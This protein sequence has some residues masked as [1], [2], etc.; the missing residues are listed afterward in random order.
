MTTMWNGSRLKPLEKS[1][2]YPGGASVFADQT[3]SRPQ[4]ADTVARGQARTDLP[5]YE[6]RE[7]APGR[8]LV[9]T[10]PFP[11]TRQILDRGEERFNIYCSPCH[12]LTGAGNGMIV[13]RGFPPPPSYYIPRLRQA[14]V[15]HLYDVITNGYGV[16]YSYND[17]VQPED[18]W[19]IVAYIRALPGHAAHRLDRRVGGKALWRGAAASVS[20]S[21]DTFAANTTFGSRA[22][23]PSENT[24]KLLTAWR[25]RGLLLG[26]GL[27]V[28]ALLGGIFAPALFFPAYLYAWLFWLG[29]A[30]GSLGIAMMHHLTGGGWG[31]VIRRILEAAFGTLP[32][33]ALLF[34]P[35]LFGLHYLYPWADPARMAADPILRDKHGM[36]T[37]PFFLARNIL[38][39]V[40]WIALA[41]ILRAWSVEQDRTGDPAITER[42]QLWCGPGLVLYVFT[43]SL[44]AIDWIMS[45]EPR[46]FSTIFGMLIVAGQ[47]L[48][49][50][51]F[52]I[53]IAHRLAL[54]AEGER[55]KKDGKTGSKKKRNSLFALLAILHIW[56]IPRG[57]ASRQHERNKNL[58]ANIHPPEL[59]EADTLDA[60]LAPFWQDLGGMMLA[61]VLLWVYMSY[62]Q[63]IIIWSGDLPSETSFYL[64]RQ[65]GGW[66]VFVWGLIALHFALPFLLLLFGG[67][68]RRAGPLFAIAGLLLIA[69][70][71]H[72]FWLVEPK[73]YPHGFGFSW[74]DVVTP[75]AI[76]GLWLAVFSAALQSAALLP[77]HDP[78]LQKPVAAAE[79]R[80][81][82]QDLGETKQEG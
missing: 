37:L 48:T 9:T 29:I 2:V 38:Y 61:F 65:Q 42:F 12:G 10:F 8:P 18:R 30:L 35:L 81:A 28:L 68:K 36:F 3:S 70:L 24:M 49:A 52:A 14:P 1:P 78:R 17:R 45:L 55:Q 33:L 59:T 51:A 75:L 77:L 73:F 64:H 20:C 47:G 31:F 58:D 63:Y 72:T 5:L 56:P 6:G 13:Q 26:G 74:L 69:H 41:R 76:G 79:A 80:H 23:K 40:V 53:V 43:M 15:G 11:I 7:H 19:A 82:R 46:W 16:M 22:M 34:L 27:S 39:F 21:A 4:V 50:L 60:R 25:Q 32:L 57:E 44:A 66:K 67:I 62:S 71:L 54:I